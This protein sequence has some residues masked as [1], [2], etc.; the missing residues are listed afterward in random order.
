MAANQALTTIESSGKLLGPLL[1]GLILSFASTG[2]VMFVTAASCAIATALIAAI[3]AW[4]T[5]RPTDSG[6]EAESGGTRAG[7]RAIHGDA[8]LRLVV[9]LYCA[10]NFVTGGLNVLLVICAIKL[11][12]LGSSGLGLLNGVIGAGGMV[13][14]IAVG[15][16]LGPRRIASNLG[17]GLFLC[18]APIAIVAA[19]PGTAA[20][21][22]LFVVLGAGITICD[23]TAVT[24]LQR[25]ISD[26]ALAGVF[27]VLQSVFVATLG[28]GTFLAPEL[29]SALGLRATLGLLG[30]G[31]IIPVALSWSSLARLDGGYLRTEEAADLL[32]SISIFEPLDLPT[33]ERL[34]RAL[35]PFDAPA[36]NVIIQE[37]DEGDR[38]YA[39]AAGELLVSIDGQPVRTLHRGD[40]FGEIA[41]LRGVPRTSTVTASTDVRLLALERETFL[42]AVAGHPE[43]RNAAEAIIDIRLGSLRAGLAS[44]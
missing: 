18:G 27:S 7:L 4:E 37:G 14:A 1:G 41:L 42:A 5:P 19:R 32:R 10:E 43:S 39:I 28:L 34:A 33:I 9:A 40:G 12:S 38:Y 22:V 2:A 13:G 21:L 26:D 20:T 25:A 36:G 29:V 3:P 16:V 11:L 17:T 15:A 6:R 35:I 23:F 44:V 31:L 8:S 30:V 24:L